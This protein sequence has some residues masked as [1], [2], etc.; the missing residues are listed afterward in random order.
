MS[1]QAAAKKNRGRSRLQMLKLATAYDQMAAR[2][3][4]AASQNTDN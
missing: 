3:M 1:F 2:L 4:V